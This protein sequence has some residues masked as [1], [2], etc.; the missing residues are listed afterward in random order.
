MNN[1]TTRFARVRHSLKDLLGGEFIQAACAARARLTGEEEKALRALAAEKIDFYPV[2]LYRR[3]VDW[4][5]RV[6][7]ACC[8]PVRSTAPGATSQEFQAHSKPAIAPLNCLGFYRVSEDGRL[9]LTSK[10]EHY[11]VA[12]GHHFPGYQ[13]L[14]RAR[15]LGI[16]NATHNVTRGQVTRILEQ[17]LVRAAAGRSRDEIPESPAGTGRR[18]GAALDRVLNLETGSLAAETAIKMVLARFYRPLP[19]SPPP[20]YQGRTPVFVVLG[21]YQGGLQANYHGTAVVAQWMRGMWPE[22]LEGLE[23]HGLL[24]VR[25][26]RP[27]DERELEAVFAEYNQGRY[28]TAAFFHEFIMMNYGAARLT[29]S[30]IRRAYALCRKHDTPTVA[31]E[32]QTCVWS[33]EIFMFREYGVTPSIAVVGKGFPG[34]E[35]PASR[36]LFNAA[37]DTLPL[38]GALVTNG[39][40]ELASLAYLVTLRWAEANAEVTGAVGDYYEERLRDLAARHSGPLAS[41]EGRRHLAGINFHELGTGRRFAKILNEAGL[42]ISVQTYKEGCPPSALTKLPL[43]AGYEVVDV[44][45]A[46]MEEALRAIDPAAAPHRP[47]TNGRDGRARASRRNEKIPRRKS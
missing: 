18:H 24:R 17:E 14:E 3:L 44:V 43:T 35:Y 42:D 7:E 12:L 32:I 1:H 41:I 10:S 34:G 36:I 23:K 26:V 8:P 30:Y 9:F 40:E 28:K 4:L 27:N 5:P 19:V 13:L 46:R 45:L 39:Q 11:H 31:D 47:S 38:F 33:P 6:G 16:S 15:R 21:D 20:K 22:L 25:G 2:E 37:L 29:D